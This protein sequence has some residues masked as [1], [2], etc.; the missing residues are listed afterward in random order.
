MSILCSLMRWQSVG[1]QRV[2]M[3]IRIWNGGCAIQLR[4][5]AFED[6]PLKRVG[7]TGRPSVWFVSDAGLENEE[8][9]TN[10]HDC[11]NFSG[12]E[13]KGAHR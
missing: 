3:R 13:L 8:G 1:Y 12:E 5:G 7:S 10:S 9:L 4:S 2:C 6:E 11:A